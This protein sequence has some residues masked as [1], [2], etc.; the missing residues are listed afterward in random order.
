MVSGV[1]LLV[2]VLVL[3]VVVAAVRAARTPAVPH[4]SSG[5]DSTGGHEG[6]GRLADD[7]GRWVALGLLSGRQADA[8]L[9]HEQRSPA[10]LTRASPERTS[11]PARGGPAI[12]EALGYLGGILAGTGL[13]L[14]VANYWSDLATAGR[15]ALTGAGAVGLLVAGA[16]VREG[17]TPALSRLRWFLWLTATA[18]TA[19]WM[20][21]LVVD[22]FG[23]HAAKTVV[24]ACAGAVALESGMLWWR[25]DR[26]LQLLTCLGG[27]SV[28]AG[29]AAAELTTGG[30]VAGAGLA[31]W[32]VGAAYLGL[33]LRRMLSPAILPETV[34]A[35]SVVVGGVIVASDWQGAGLALLVTTAL[36]LLGLATVPGVALERAGQLTLGIVGGIALLQATPS[37]IGYFS[38]AA[39]AATGFVVFAI[40]TALIVVGERHLVRLAV[41]VNAIGCIVVIGGAALTGIQWHG[42]APVFGIVTALGLVVLGIRP[43]QVLLSLFGSVG[44]LINVPWAILH[45]FPGEG[46]APLLVLVC[47]VLILAIAVLLSLRT[48]RFDHDVRTRRHRHP[49]TGVAPGAT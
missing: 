33:G 1:L 40:G 30:W 46:R 36:G 37:A 8:I 6:P 4:P 32:M 5:V 3:V 21:V 27:T 10:P 9:A 44:L 48:G 23:T 34:G 20:R 29:A 47:G 25:R 41:A 42:F 18:M 2:A 38:H 15:L 22:G 11:R 43:G 26:P 31:V 49:P 13:L 16:L 19:V 35:L 14:L 45:F 17:A 28:F 39:A 7:L 24:A 12:A